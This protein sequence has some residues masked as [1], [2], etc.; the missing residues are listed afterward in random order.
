MPAGPANCCLADDVLVAIEARRATPGR[1]GCRARSECRPRPVPRRAEPEQLD[2]EGGVGRVGDRVDVQ[3]LDV[4]RARLDVVGPVVVERRVRSHERLDDAADLRQA[5]VLADRRRR[6][7]ALVERRAGVRWLHP[8]RRKP[9]EFQAPHLVDAALV[10]VGRHDRLEPD[11]PVGDELG[12]LPRRQP[13]ICPHRH[14]SARR[15]TRGQTPA[16]TPTDSDATRQRSAAADSS[17]ASRTRTPIG[18]VSSYPARW[19]SSSST[20]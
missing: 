19:R 7:V 9:F 6:R 4:G 8:V 16:A 1:G 14:E 20:W 12:H 15:Y 3:R 10:D 5:E 17:R 2:V 13:M 18:A 11:E